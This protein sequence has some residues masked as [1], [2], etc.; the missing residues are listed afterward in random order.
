MNHI[1]L[2]VMSILFFY[3]SIDEV[4]ACL[5]HNFFRYWCAGWALA[6]LGNESASANYLPSSSGG[7]DLCIGLDGRKMGFVGVDVGLDSVVES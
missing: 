4:L 2:L 6:R 3:A 1:A 7:Y 5:A